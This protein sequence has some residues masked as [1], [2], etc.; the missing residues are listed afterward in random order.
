M[1]EY[2]PS[3]EMVNFRPEEVPLEDI[4]VSQRSLWVAN[5]QQEFFSRL[6]D[7]A[8]CTSVSTQSLGPIGL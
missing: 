3:L 6:R 8:P 1:G 2:M 7:E 5:R 4:D